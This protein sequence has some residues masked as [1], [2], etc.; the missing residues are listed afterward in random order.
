MIAASAL[1]LFSGLLPNTLEQ[2]VEK[3]KTILA[4]ATSTL[5]ADYPVEGLFF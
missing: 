2:V 4:T 3:A 5:E 1:W